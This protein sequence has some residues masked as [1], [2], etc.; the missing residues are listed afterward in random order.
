MKRHVRVNVTAG[1]RKEKIVALSPDH[2]LMAVR[3]KAE[4]NVANRKVFELLANIL[5]L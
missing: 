4:G 5:W 2:F 1:A 3:E